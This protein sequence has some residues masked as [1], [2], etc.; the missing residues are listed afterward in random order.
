MDVTKVKE[1]NMYVIAKIYNENRFI[2]KKGPNHIS[3]TMKCYIKCSYR[4]LVYHN[5]IFKILKKYE[6]LHKRTIQYENFISYNNRHKN[7]IKFF[8]YR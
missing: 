4:K 6:L 2:I 8:S 7:S 1:E 3:I 5:S